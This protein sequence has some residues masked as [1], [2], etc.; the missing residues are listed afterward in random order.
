MRNWNKVIEVGPPKTGTTSLGQAFDILGLKYRKWDPELY[1]QY[2]QGD[3]TQI[4]EIAKHYDAFE[5]GPWHCEV[6]Y[7]LLDRTF[8]NSKFILLERDLTVGWRAT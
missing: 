5:D 1:D 8:P 6:V 3:Y 2:E 4:L 7:Q